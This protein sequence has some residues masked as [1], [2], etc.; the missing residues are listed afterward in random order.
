MEHN[1]HVEDMLN[2]AIEKIKN[3][4]DTKTVVGEPIE[5]DGAKVVPVIKITV[6]LVAGGGEYS[7][8]D[9]MAKKAK[10]YPFAGGTGTG[11]N[12]QPIGFLYFS[13][14][15]VKYIKLDSI[16]PLDKFIDVLPKL[17]ESISNAIKEKKN[18]NK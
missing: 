2:V 16:S 8:T 4:A 18:E 10:T 14:D 17:S 6:G 5:V 3:I 12:V 13:N 15:L 7:A 11:I 9:K 1:S